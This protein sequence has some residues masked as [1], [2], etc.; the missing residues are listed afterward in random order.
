MEG[1]VISLFCDKHI[2]DLYLTME[3]MYDKKVSMEIG[4][5]FASLICGWFW[6]IACH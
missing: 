4:S 2:R 6:V 5:M 1:G 3:R